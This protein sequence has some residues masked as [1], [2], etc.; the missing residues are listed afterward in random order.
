MLTD[1]FTFLAFDREGRFSAGCSSC[2]NEVDVKIVDIDY[3]ITRSVFLSIA[4]L[5]PA[6]DDTDYDDIGDAE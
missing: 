6:S 3:E 5:D 1:L 4:L 2:W